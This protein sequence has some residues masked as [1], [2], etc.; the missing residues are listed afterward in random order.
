MDFQG[1]RTLNALFTRIM[2]MFGRGVLKSSALD[3][4]GR[5]RVQFTSLKGVVKDDVEHMQNYGFL[6]LSRPGA[7]LIYLCVG[8]NHDHPVVIAARDPKDIPENVKSMIQPGD[9]VMYT[10]EGAKVHLK[11][12]REIE[13]EADT[14]ILKASQKVRFETPE[15]EVTGNITD[16][17][18]LDG[19]S[20]K[21]MRDV[22]D[23]HD[24]DENN[25]DNGPTDEPNQKMGGA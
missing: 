1:K 7:P 12:G 6:S 10:H 4:D 17:C 9:A 5:A 25:T 19:K 22:Y 18:D 13:V 2:L 15:F 8:G 21:S 16:L 11:A 14:F 23:I 3:A 24:H 20:L